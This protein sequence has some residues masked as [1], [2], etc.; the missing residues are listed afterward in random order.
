MNSGAKTQTAQKR[1]PLVCSLASKLTA[2]EAARLDAFTN[3][4]PHASYMQKTSWVNLSP[5]RRLRDFQFVTCT[6]GGELCVAGLAR[7]SKLWGGMY[8]AKFMRGPVFNDVEHF[9]RALPYLLNSLREIGVC[10][11]IMN[12]RWEDDGAQQVEGL[13]AS[14]G[15]KRLARRDQSMYTS[16]ALVDLTGQEQEILDGFERRCRKDI[17]RGVKKGVTVRPA[18]NEEEARLVRDR[19]EELVAFRNFESF[20]HPDLVDQWRSFQT[21]KDGLL[22][23]AEAKGQVIAGLAVAREGDRAVARGGGA[24]PTLPTV[25]RLHNLLWESMRMFKEQGCTVYDLA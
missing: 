7:L 15:M 8:M 23:L 16:T 3:S 18:A 1:R 10:T 22:L 11:V 14:H 9:D 5:S 4:G 2:G 17:R 12:P 6:I 21:N 13:F 25:P 19:R 20:G 24:P